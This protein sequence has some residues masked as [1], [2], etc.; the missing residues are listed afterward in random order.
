[1]LCIGVLHIHPTASIITLPERPDLKLLWNVHS[2]GKS[3]VGYCLAHAIRTAAVQGASE[4]GHV[5]SAKRDC[6]AMHFT[7][8]SMSLVVLFG[9]LHF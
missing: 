7:V 3:T 5:Q 4:K 9:S 1:M 8:A 6:K 2:S